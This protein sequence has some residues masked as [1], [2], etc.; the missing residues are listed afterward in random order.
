[1]SNGLIILDRDGILNKLI[2]R[3]DG[4]TDSPMSI[5]EVIIFPW[6]SEQL[7]ILKKLGYILAIATNQPAAAKGKTSLD[8]LKNVHSYIEQKIQQNNKLISKSFI[9]FHRSEDNC[10][11]RKPKIGLLKYA[12]DMLG[13]ELYRQNSWMIGDR[14]TDI[15]AGYNFGI[16]TALLG[17]SV[18]E[19][20]EIL[21][22]F[23]IKPTYHGTDLQ[24]FVKSIS[25]L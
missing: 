6:V 7:N 23:N 1:M 24:D 8:N 2:I 9:C 19:D 13:N 21:N 10:E 15:I 18:P 20:I 22:N 5:D 16:K 4:S 11:C 12:F 17:P 25:L 3:S 14:A